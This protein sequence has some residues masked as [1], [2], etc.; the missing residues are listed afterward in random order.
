M[1]RRLEVS[2]VEFFNVLESYVCP[3]LNIRTDTFRSLQTLCRDALLQR[4][5]QHRICNSEI[6]ITYN[7]ITKTVSNDI[8]VSL[9]LEGT[10]N[11]V[12]DLLLDGYV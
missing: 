2:N 11:V 10:C 6:D 4:Y 7:N 9:R 8:T 5:E 3:V 1:L 12:N